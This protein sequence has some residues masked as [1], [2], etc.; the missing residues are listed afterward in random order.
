EGRVAA[1]RH[2]ADR[3]EVGRLVRG[4]ALGQLVEPA[5]FT[6]LRQDGLLPL[7]LGE[8]PT[9]RPAAAHEQRQAEGHDG[10]LWHGDPSRWEGA[11]EARPPI[12]SP[13][14]PP[15]QYESALT[16]SLAA[17]VPRAFQVVRLT[18]LLTKRTDPSAKLTLT[19]LPAW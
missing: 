7:L 1:G 15:A 12:M 13:A 4:L 16:T 19:P 6:E 3:R 11:E 18:V 17:R 5:E 8:R 9:R 2:R 10:R 14:R